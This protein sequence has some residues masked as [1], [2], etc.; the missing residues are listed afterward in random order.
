MM[1]VGDN[2]KKWDKLMADYL[3]S[4]NELMPRMRMVTETKGGETK[5]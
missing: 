3:C 4:L 2:G 5:Y 1:E